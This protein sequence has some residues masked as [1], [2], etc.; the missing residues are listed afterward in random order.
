MQ[1]KDLDRM[2]L[3][4]ESLFQE[5]QERVM[6]DI[7]RRIQKTGKIT[8]TADYQ[9]EKL[10]LFGKS[11]EFIESEL[12]RLTGKTEPMI[13]QLYEDVIDKEYARNK[14]I[15]EQVNGNFIPYEENELLQQWVHAI[16]NQTNDEIKNLTRS[17]GFALKYAGKTVFTPFSEYYQKYLDRACMEIITGVFDYNTVLRRV[18]S[19]MTSSGI[20]TVDY[21]S[22]HSNRITVAGRRAVMT[23][24][25][26]L[27]SKINEK[28]A[29]D[30]GTNTFEVTWHAGA[31]PTHWWGGMVF[32]KE[33]LEN[34]CGL[35]RVDGLCGA[36]CRHNYIAFVPGISKRTYADEQLAE[37]R[38]REKK[39]TRWRGKDYNVYEATQKQRQMET[40][41]RAQRERV[42]LLQ[43]GGADKE[44]V[45]IEKA[46][47]QGQLNEYAR[48]S[49]IMGLIQ[50]RE[51]IYLDLRG[52]VAPITKFRR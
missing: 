19:E 33:E 34:V 48:F 15:Y 3:Q 35:G 4:I 29:K 49:R 44:I 40:A 9:I 7:V 28:V 37:M 22:G 5:M 24:V 14:A 39:T 26:Q 30:L 16:A 12:K 21:A 42:R 31:R 43:S 2:S 38:E 45:M 41:M 1:P 32:T 47:Y 46:K 10:I 8:S 17:M 18:V 50:Q 23:G 13:W 52:R 6:L 20:R 36:N 51:R 27:S 11:S 25:N